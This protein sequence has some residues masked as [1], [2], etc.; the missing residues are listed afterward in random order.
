MADRLK[1]LLT[2]IGAVSTVAVSAARADAHG[3]ELDVAYTGD[4]WTSLSGGISQDSAY[5]DNLDVLIDIDADDLWGLPGTHIFI[6]GLYNNGGE[7]SSSYVGDSQV[8]SNIET[9]VSAVRLYEIWLNV[10]LSPKS[11][12]RFGLYDLN[13]EFDVLES[14]QLFVGSAHGIG[15]DIS[16]SGSNGPSI[17]PSTSLSLRLARKINEAWTARIA[18]LD[19][20]P[21]NPDSPAQTKIDLGGDD[22]ALVIGELQRQSG[23]SR[24]LAGAWT[25]T[26]K[27]ELGD[28]EVRNTGA[29]LR[30]EVRISDRYGDLFVFGRYGVA[31]DEVNPF[32]QFVSGGIYS[33]GFVQQRPDDEVGIAFAWAHASDAADD[34]LDEEEIAIELTYRWQVNDRFAIQ[35]DIQYIINPGL[36][37]SLDDAFVAGLRLE[38]QFF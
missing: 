31:N 28:R 7:F 6:Y 14:S 3:F 2:L 18:V 20:V 38:A 4:V 23:K 27:V 5:L 15:T 25:Y 35:P 32:S 24:M 10:D 9:G 29:Y 36:D 33:R 34:M 12:L 26:K 21:G 17:F 8:V 1:Y 16:Q 11:D 37:P 13:S 19:G 22:G 30:G